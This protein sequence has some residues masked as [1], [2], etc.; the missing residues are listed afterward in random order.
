MELSI[1]PLYFCFSSK[2]NVAFFS[3]PKLV[4]AKSLITVAQILIN[5]ITVLI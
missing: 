3:L 4:R 1:K 5:F 2:L